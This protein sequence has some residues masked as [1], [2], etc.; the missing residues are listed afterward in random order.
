MEVTYRGTEINFELTRSYGH[1]RIN[2]YNKRGDLIYTN[3]VTDSMAY[4]DYKSLRNDCYNSKREMKEMLK[5]VRECLI[6]D[7][8][9]HQTYQGF[10][11]LQAY[12]AWKGKK[13]NK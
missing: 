7:K 10:P 1:Y 2:Q 5:N 6:S 13:F 4:D 3:I 9:R 8:Y 11:S 12:E